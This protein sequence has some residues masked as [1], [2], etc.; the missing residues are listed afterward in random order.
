MPKTTK[1]SFHRYRDEDAVTCYVEYTVLA[2]IHW[3]V[4]PTFMFYI[5]FD[6]YNNVK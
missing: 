6:Q 3:P 4:L 2:F 5:N 1:V